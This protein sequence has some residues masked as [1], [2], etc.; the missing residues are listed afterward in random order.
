MTTLLACNTSVGRKESVNRMSILIAIISHRSI[1]LTINTKSMYETHS[2]S[3]S[4][5]DQILM[6]LNYE[7]NAHGMVGLY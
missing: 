2:T 1:H 7:A 5:T 6:S 3:R 4:K